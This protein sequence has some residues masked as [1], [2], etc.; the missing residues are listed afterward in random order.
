MINRD[1]AHEAPPFQGFMGDER[2]GR[3]NFL[4]RP[5]WFYGAVMIRPPDLPA[6]FANIAFRLA[7]VVAGSAAH[8]LQIPPEGSNV[9]GSKTQG[10]N[11]Q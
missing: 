11:L 7:A 8:S 3:K 2:T 1:L 4:K 10:I 5:F 6:A 9:G